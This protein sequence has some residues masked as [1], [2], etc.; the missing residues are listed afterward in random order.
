MSHKNVGSS[1]VNL[2][3]N[4]KKLQIRWKVVDEKNKKIKF[5][6]VKI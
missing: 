2:W 5:K 6:N 4:T 1:N 3:K